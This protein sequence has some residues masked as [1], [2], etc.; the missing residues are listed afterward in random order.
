MRDTNSRAT[1]MPVMPRQPAVNAPGLPFQDRS[2][3]EPLP[4]RA[5]PTKKAAKRATKTAVNPVAAKPAAKRPAKPTAKAASKASLSGSDD[6]SD[7]SDEESSDES[8]DEPEYE[9]LEILKKRNNR[10]IQ[11]LVKWA[12]GPNG[13]KYEPTWEPHKNVGLPL[14]AE[15]DAKNPAAK[16]NLGGNCA[17]RSEH[18]HVGTSALDKAYIAAGDVPLNVPLAASRPK[19]HCKDLTP[20][21][22]APV[23][24]PLAPVKAPLAPVEAP[25]EQQLTEPLTKEPACTNLN[26]EG[27][28][29]AAQDDAL[30]LSAEAG[31]PDFYSH[32]RHR[33]D[34]FNLKA[35]V[36]R[37]DGEGTTNI[38]TLPKDKAPYTYTYVDDNTVVTVVD[39]NI[40]T[41]ESG[42]EYKQITHGLTSGFIRAAYL[43]SVE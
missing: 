7:E 15:Y 34:S 22:P 19:R 37:N 23:E 20:A 4:P 28:P 42:V 13:E 16:P 11:Y 39:N 2:E 12:D 26:E 24:A 30:T 5:P 17:S 40:Y 43:Q 32:K 18:E 31:A 33:H 6:D 14:I 35:L 3:A 10:G 1:T 29:A 25:A 8:D 41:S 9:A 38:R 36:K 27:A 21:P